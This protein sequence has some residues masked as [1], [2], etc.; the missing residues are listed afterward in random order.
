MKDLLPVLQEFNTQL[1]A[2]NT[3][4]LAFSGGLDSSCLLHL[5]KQAKLSP[6]LLHVNHQLSPSADAWATH[7]KK[8]AERYGFPI[9]VEHVS[10]S[11]S[12]KG[13]ENA[14]RESRYEVF[15]KY[16]QSGD[17]LLTAHHL[18]DQVETV[19][20]RLLRGAGSRG[21]SGINIERELGEARM[22]RPLLKVMREELLDYAKLNELSW[23]EDE[24]NQNTNLDR[25]F[26]R[27]NIFPL[28]QGRWPGFA[29]RAAEASS[30]LCQTGALL[31]E[32]A[33]EDILAC[34]CRTERTGQSLKIKKLLSLSISRRQNIIR[35]WISDLG[36]N[37]PSRAQMEQ[38]EWLLVAKDDAQPHV[39]IG[40]YEL[41][42]Y[43][44]RVYCMK[45]LCNLS[46]LQL[47]ELPWD[48]S[49][50]LNLRGAGRIEQTAGVP[51]E[52]SIRFRRGGERCKPHGRD[53]SQRLKKLLQEY[54]LEPWL[55]D[56]I[57]LVFLRGELVA[58]GDLFTCSENAD[59]RFVLTY[60]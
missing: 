35:T 17:C 13:L 53:K 29:R 32:Y 7:C 20:F 39:I 51:Q 4:Y 56:R 55:R 2:A 6:T 15:L 60:L 46:E 19:F 50:P 42:R 38:L 36:F 41:R 14:A 40:N 30:S 11:N 1:N 24:S 33:R 16:L 9:V 5:L 43:N 25:N 10:V 8:V 58:V 49:R 18:D 57:P 12:G 21:L 22:L 47:D 54:G 37:L 34:E 48:S 3:L 31:D 28:L 59:F 45:K 44:Q 23:V 27:Q 52:F 26:L